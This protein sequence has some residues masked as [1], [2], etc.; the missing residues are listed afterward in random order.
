MLQSRLD[1]IARSIDDEIDTALRLGAEAVAAAARE[2]VVVDSGDLKNSIHVER[3]GIDVYTVVAGDDDVY[4]GH[5]VENG[6]TRTPPRPFLVPSLEANRD[7]I[8]RAVDDALE[9]L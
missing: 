6:T 3:K 4:Y 9:N 7:N 2:R 8:L 5:M 1:N